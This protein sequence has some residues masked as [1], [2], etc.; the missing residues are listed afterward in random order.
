MLNDIDPTMQID[1]PGLGASGP[2][3][4]VTAFPL[5]RIHPAPWNPRKHFD[6]EQLVSLAQDIAAQG[7]LQALVL[8]P[9]PGGP[10]DHYEI[11]CGE[12]RYRASLRAGLVEVPAT[13]RE[14]DD[15]A[16]MECAL[17]ENG[18]RS[19]LHPIEEADGFLALHTVHGES[20]EDI[21]TRFGVSVK[22]V[23]GRLALAKL[24][25]EGRRAFLDGKLSW[26]VALRIARLTTLDYQ[27]E[28]IEQLVSKR[29][30][31]RPPLTIEEAG[32]WIENRYHLRLADAP[33]DTTN[34]EL[35]AGVGACT[36]CPKNTD[37]QLQLLGD[38]DGIRG[39]QC[40]DPVCF[41][42]K[43][44]AAWQ[45]ATAALQAEGK[46]VLT[47]D[48]SAS[49]MPRYGHGDME[50][51]YARPDDRPRDLGGKKS[52]RQILGKHMPETVLARDRDGNAVEVIEPAALKAAMKAAGVEPKKKSKSGGT[53]DWKAEQAKREAERELKSA[54]HGALVTAFRDAL[55]KRTLEDGSRAV[56]QFLAMAVTMMIDPDVSDAVIMARNK[57]KMPK[58][59]RGDAYAAHREE[60][61]SL[62]PSGCRTYL[63]DLIFE[64]LS[65]ESRMDDSDLRELVSGFLKV[66]ADAIEKR[67]R[68]EATK[69]KAEAEAAAA[70]KAAS[71]KGSKKPAPKAPTKRDT[72]PANVSKP[73]PKPSSKPAA[74]SAPE[75]AAAPPTK[76][77][78]TARTP[79]VREPHIPRA[80]WEGLSYDQRHKLEWVNYPGSTSSGYTVWKV[81]GETVTCG[82][83]NMGTSYQL[84]LVRIAE[85]LGI[86]MTWELPAP[87]TAAK[88]PAKK[89]PS[90]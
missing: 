57:G 84:A 21:A 15:R 32:R 5:D 41:S 61:G 46:K 71:K 8:R 81:V 38:G 56:W 63:F 4:T 43:R 60:V 1:H 87:K 24:C 30:H 31:W 28:A 74:K 90:K 52:L 22:L 80:Q 20:V 76:P 2:T 68:A 62:S 72:K 12:R 36:T 53:Y 7:I 10:A 83:L 16:A 14:L 73:A 39:G 27:R 77:V 18:Q 19:N 70:E 42:R 6:E 23:H 50:K 82:G 29:E 58:F 89:G 13:V 34:A 79:E 35:L 66:D 49:I 17:S 78:E 86:T 85:E 69:K 55:S 45:L 37:A 9:R 44:E 40:T 3:T 75:P 47:A 88:K 51:G 59:V 33:F 65:P 54:V 11:V 67:A 26:G 48:A 64:S 25:D